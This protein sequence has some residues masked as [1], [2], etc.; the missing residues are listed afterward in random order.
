VLARLR[1]IPGAIDARVECSGQLFLLE[2]EH[3]AD[4]EAAF[5]S[6][7]DVLGARAQRIPD[8]VAAVHLEA[9]ARG[10]PWFSPDDI[11]GLS[12]IEGRVL[13]S[14]IGDAVLRRVPL[15]RPQA[16][17]LRDAVLVQIRAALDRVHDEGG[18]S[19]SAWFD[20]AWPEIAER[21]VAGV[22][23]GIAEGLLPELRRAVREA[24]G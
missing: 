24:H 20:A 4:P 22:R 8:T 10:E 12:Y 7:R 2:L 1:G 21:I 6:A 18:R 17:L 15:E 16:E 23:D 11:R 3:G 5:A 14:R 19:S 9:R 13:A